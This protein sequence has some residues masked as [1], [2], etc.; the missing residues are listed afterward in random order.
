MHPASLAT[1][2]ARQPK[3]HF[4]LPTHNANQDLCGC[5]RT[6]LIN[7][8]EPLLVNYGQDAGGDR[9]N[10]YYKLTGVHNFLQN[11]TANDLQSGDVVAIIDGFDVWSQLPADVLL[12]RFLRSGKRILLGVDKQCFPNDPQSP[13]C[14]DIPESPLPTDVYGSKTDTDPIGEPRHFT[15]PRW[16]NSGTV[17]GYFEDVRRLYESMTH[18]HDS[19]DDR[20]SDQRIF[21]IH[22]YW[23]NFSISL[24]FNAEVTTSVAFSEDDLQYMNDKYVSEVGIGAWT[25]PPG[26]ENYEQ[27][28]ASVAAG[29]KITRAPILRYKFTKTVPV[30]LHFP[31]VAKPRMNLYHER[32]WWAVKR[33][34]RHEILNAYV[35]NKKIRVVESGNTLRFWEVR[36]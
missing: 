33:E 9:Q 34:K 15:R 5:I 30:F 22:Y 20:T 23:G 19:D 4:L 6:H 36:T 18:F 27:T 17:V 31:G 28:I 24:D 1:V 29:T 3:L 26:D 32:M 21:A 7:G 13:V 35:M 25:L 8:F 14:N 12:E 2:P 10:K 16:V 11:A